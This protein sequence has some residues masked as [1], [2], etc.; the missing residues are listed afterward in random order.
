MA[1]VAD[2]KAFSEWEAYR[3]ALK[4]STVVDITETYAQKQA[5]IK[6]LE[7]NFEDWVK[8][9]FEN[10]CKDPVTGVFIEPAKFHKD[11]SKRI[12]NNP[13]WVEVRA[14]SRELAKSTRTM[15]EIMYLT[16]TGKKRNVILVSNSED[17]EAIKG[18]IKEVIDENGRTVLTVEPKSVTEKRERIAKDVFA[19]NTGLS[20]IFFTSDMM[21]F[22]TKSDALNH[23]FGLTNK[24][25]T[26]INKE[27]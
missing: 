15:F 21:P 19:N 1:K 24:K 18:L 11:S 9:Y 3:E 27:D 12:L 25:V 2:K 22:R 8:Y 20:V 17:K 5:R 6:R 13:E 7:S 10:S 14:W 4:R 23:A 16:L 26:P